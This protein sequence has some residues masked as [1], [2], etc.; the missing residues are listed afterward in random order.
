M[1]LRPVWLLGEDN[2]EK[3]CSSLRGLFID[4]LTTMIA[5]RGENKCY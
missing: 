4:E 5:T 2:G 1:D 3:A